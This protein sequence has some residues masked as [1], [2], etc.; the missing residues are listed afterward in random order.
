MWHEYI[1]YVIIAGAFSYTAYRVF[2]VLGNPEDSGACATCTEA[3]KLKGMKRPT[4]RNK[5][6][7]CV[8]KG[9][10]HNK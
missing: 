5:K 10:K 2:K 3:C 7:N 9:E 1:A 8:H 4:Q 6:K